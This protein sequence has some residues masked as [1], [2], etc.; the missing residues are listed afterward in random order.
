[1]MLACICRTIIQ[2]IVLKRTNNSAIKAILDNASL[3]MSPS[4]SQDLEK[5][6]SASTTTSFSRLVLEENRSTE[7]EVPRWYLFSGQTDSKVPVC[8]KKALG[9]VGG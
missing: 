5:R 7:E 1:M 2:Y 8:L 4:L 9:F 6:D 3:V